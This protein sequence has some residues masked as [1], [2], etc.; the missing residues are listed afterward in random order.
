M[1]LP[2]ISYCSKDVLL[3]VKELP[4]SRKKTTG[5]EYASSWNP[6]TVDMAQSINIKFAKY[7]GKKIIN[8]NNGWFAKIGHE[9][10]ENTSK[11]QE[12]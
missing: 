7:S 1:F 8:N 10:A 3:S 4:I 5:I 9:P 12:V 11:D 2:G 6:V